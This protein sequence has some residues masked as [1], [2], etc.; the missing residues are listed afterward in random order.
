ML[1]ITRLLS[2]QQMQHANHG[3]WHKKEEE[4]G[5]QH[6]SFHGNPVKATLISI[7]ARFLKGQYG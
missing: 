6:Q 7:S 4:K 3:R 5:L 1:C 2:G